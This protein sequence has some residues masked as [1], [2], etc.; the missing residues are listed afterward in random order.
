[1]IVVVS[2]MTVCWA[3]DG[4]IPLVGRVQLRSDIPCADHEDVLI[5]EILI[6]LLLMLVF[7]EVSGLLHHNALQ[8]SN[9]APNWFCQAPFAWLS[10]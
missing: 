10:Q 9:L 5:L 3:D 6:S 7:E 1:M 8:R 2:E 4:V